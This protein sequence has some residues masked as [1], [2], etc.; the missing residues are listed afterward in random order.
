MESVRD[1]VC[2]WCGREGGERGPRCEGCGAVGRSV[3]VEALRRALA[4][5]GE[6]AAGQEIAVAL[7][8]LA[9]GAA[10]AEAREW[11]LARV[12]VSPRAG[13]LVAALGRLSDPIA[14]AEATRIAIENFREKRLPGRWDVVLAEQETPAARATLLQAITGGEEAAVWAAAQAMLGAWEE[15]PTTAFPPLRELLGSD[16][17][18][19][20]VRFCAAVLLARGGDAASWP[21][22]R[23]WLMAALE[24]GPDADAMVEPTSAATVLWRRGGPQERERA[25]QFLLER[26][27]GA[28][29]PVLERV[30]P[31]LLEAPDAALIDALVEACRR[32]RVGSPS[33]ERLAAA[34]A[35][36]RESS[37]VGEALAALLRALEPA[38]A[39]LPS[40][41]ATL[42]AALGHLGHPGALPW[43]VERAAAAD[44]PALQ[45]A[46]AAAQAR[47]GA[48]VAIARCAAFLL[49]E[50]DDAFSVLSAD[51]TRLA[52]VAAV[53]GS[54]NRPSAVPVVVTALLRALETPRVAPHAARALAAL[55]PPAACR[56]ETAEAVGSVPTTLTAAETTIPAAPAAAQAAAADG[57]A[58][59]P[60]L[61]RTREWSSPLLPAVP[62]IQ[63]VA[64]GT[65][66]GLGEGAT[67]I[68]VTCWRPKPGVE[69]AEGAI[70]DA[71]S[72]YE[73]VWRAYGRRPRQKKTR[74]PRLFH[75]MG[76]QRFG[77]VA[78]ALATC[79]ILGMGYM[80]YLVAQPPAK[81]APRVLATIVVITPGTTVHSR[82][83]RQYPVIKTTRRGDCLSVIDK[84]TGWWKVIFPN[85]LTGWIERRDTAVVIPEPEPP[86]PTVAPRETAVPQAA[87]HLTRER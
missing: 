85:G 10:I 12:E 38:D 83:G 67:R 79:A 59:E 21:A 58:G 68:S 37:L 82:K 81:P 5:A 49:G 53:L 22:A 75:P 65:G 39:G 87:V 15:V 17:A 66:V 34:F 71:V 16:R 25:R 1:G 36:F 50:G 29:E 80:R 57:A 2:P 26:L 3:V 72:E 4:E 20:E 45:A 19:E 86:G 74:R 7:A 51:A 76:L 14:R 54:V 62:E 78:G 44:D 28:A 55:Y 48:P 41:E 84:T 70:P 43:L 73:W 32:R 8:R 69:S 9:G 61:D 46:I 33:A 31:V 13:E 18:P 24:A 64:S 11:L 56:D 42:I 6:D 27:M 60:S 52:S 23:P 77:G 30:L 63:P 47:L 40:R 35:S